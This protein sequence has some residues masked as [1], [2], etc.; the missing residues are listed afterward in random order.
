MIINK[1]A[2][3]PT[4][5]VDV[6]MRE[7]IPDNNPVIVSIAEVEHNGTL[8]RNLRTVMWNQFKRQK[9]NGEYTYVCNYSGKR[10]G[11]KIKSGTKHFMIILKYA[12]V[13]FNHSL[14]WFPKIQ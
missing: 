3:L 7:E 14:R 13:L 2:K 9:I 10:L 6:L 4:N 8:R 11:G 1:M 5:F 12:L